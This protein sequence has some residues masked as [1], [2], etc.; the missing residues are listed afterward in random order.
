MIDQGDYIQYKR[1]DEFHFYD[2]SIVVNSTTGITTGFVSNVLWRLGEL[3]LHLSTVI[4]SAVYLVVRTSS[5]NNSSLNHIWTSLIASNARDIVLNFSTPALF[6]SGDHL[7]VT[8][9]SLSVT[10]IAG[11]EITGW[12]VR[13]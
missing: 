11:V 3:R 10:N 4:A 12:A 1:W 7:V 6:F 5:V 13:G 2:A 9:G 8:M